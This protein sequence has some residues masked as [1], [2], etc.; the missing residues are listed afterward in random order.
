MDYKEYSRLRSIARKRIERAAAAGAGEYVRIPTV[1]EIKKSG[2]PEQYLRDVKNFLN[3][4][5][6]TLS[7]ARK[8]RTTVPKLDLPPLPPESKKRLST[9]EKAARRREQKRRSRAKRA[10]EQS[11]TTAAEGRKKVGYLRAMETVASKWR[12]AGLD[13]GNWLGVLSP[14]KA[15]QFVDYMEYR[16]SQGDFKTQY[17]IDRFIKDF[18]ELQRAGYDFADIRT[19]F[20][21]FLDMQK[22]K[23][24]NKKRTDRYGITKDE[25]DD[26]WAR[27]V[28]KKILTGGAS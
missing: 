28:E 5:G 8:E 23:R 16:F 1:A 20:D 19:D 13:V 21:S 9:E 7:A 18:G 27:F 10:V 11:A 14:K 24:K 2:N 17:V 6:T 3:T 22:Q 4:P 25:I 26:S 15:K 12:E